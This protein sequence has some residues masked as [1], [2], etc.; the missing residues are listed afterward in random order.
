[1]VNLEGDQK[2]RYVAGLFGNIAR[3][4]DFMNTLMTGGMHHGWRRRAVE[5]ATTSIHG[6]ALDIGTG[7]GDLAL[8][9]AR[10]HPI[11]GVV[12][13]DLV[14][15]MVS[16]AYDKACQKATNT[17]VSFLVGDALSLP[18]PDD[19]FACATSAFLLRNVP[20]L[21]MSLE[22]MVRVV[23]P[24]GKVIL[25]EIMPLERG[26]LVPLFR[27]YFHRIVPFMGALISRDPEAYTYL[28][29]SVDGFLSTESL[30]ELLQEVGLQDVG[31]NR[32]GLGTVVLY[33]GTMG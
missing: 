27:L 18:F 20:D 6:L 19:T 3:R 7:T 28:P 32:M 12:G 1:M 4:Y 26:A 16:L 13:V 33:W 24:G 15:T 5:K 30:R 8:A 31:Y 2:R 9:L 22:E 29:K 17:P 10:T 11:T 25:L 14:P 23:Q 21:K